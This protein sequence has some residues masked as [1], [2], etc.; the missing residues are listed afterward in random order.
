MLENEQ[1]SE[2]SNEVSSESVSTPIVD[3]HPKTVQQNRDPLQSTRLSR[4]LLVFAILFIVL[5]TPSVVERVQYSITV[6]Q[7]RAKYDVAKEYHQDLNLN[8][9]SDASRLLANYVGPSVVNVRTNLGSGQGQGSGVIVDKDGFI[10]T[11]NHVVL[12]VDS[13]EVQLSDGRRGPASVVGRDPMLDV[14]VLK[15]ELENLVAAEWGDSDQLDVGDMVWALGSPFGLQKSIT[16]G[17]L[18]AKERRGINLRRDSI[19]QEYLQ[20]DAA[21]NPGNSGGPL[22]NTE[23]QVVGINTAIIGKAYQGISFSIPSTVAKETYEKL[24]TVGYVERGFLGVTPYKVSDRIARRMGI[25][26]NQGV[27]ITQ[28]DV[29]TPAHQAG[30]QVGDVI[31]TW[32][33]NAYSDP[34]VLSQAIAGTP[35]GARVQVE[36]VRYENKEARQLDLEVVVAL[37]PNSSQ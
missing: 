25:E 24:R 37:R 6:A 12:D 3:Q 29:D 5:V 4:L 34:T 14:A 10:I 16:F 21:V 31:L 36:V 30:L 33:G 11:N 22:V 26:R 28:V 20:T 15:T 32:D 7:E 23:G 35:I 18:S 27:L 8:Q 13:V 9:V 17:I 19:Y 1:A 2:F